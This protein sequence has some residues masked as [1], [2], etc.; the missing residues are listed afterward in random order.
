MPEQQGPEQQGP[1]QQGPEQR[2]P[3]QRGPEQHGPEQRG[4][5]TQWVA[6]SGG[7]SLRNAFRNLA[8]AIPQLAWIATPDGDIHWYNRRWY[9]YTGRSFAEMRGQGWRELHHPDHLERVVARFRAALENGEE[10]EDTF[11]LR[12]H[13]GTYRW[14]LSRALP[15]RDAGGRIIQWSG[16]NTDVT[17]H[18]DAL[19]RLRRSEERFR[20]LMD[21]SSAI[22]WTT[23]GSGEFEAPQPRWMQFTGQSWEEHRG[24]GWL[25]A[26]A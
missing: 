17:E 2:G 16:T 7:A 5:G 20:T 9:E 18:R 6:G 10:W 13:D 12:R 22:I 23:P 14:F 4:T 15:L 11:P 1:E 19:D 24:W 8:D 26:K 21:A 25:E 3:E